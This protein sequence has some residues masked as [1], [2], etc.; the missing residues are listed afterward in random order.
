MNEKLNKIVSDV[1]EQ[2]ALIKDENSF[3]NLKVQS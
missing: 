2:L 1:K 3:R